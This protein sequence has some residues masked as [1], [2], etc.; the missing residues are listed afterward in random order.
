MPL[1]SFG[2][3]LTFA[4]K[5]EEENKNFYNKSVP[6][7]AAGAQKVFF[8]QLIKEKEKQIKLIQR[9]R[10]ENVSEMILEPI[11]DFKREAYLFDLDSVTC[12]TTEDIINAA[13]KIEKRNFQY[14]LE[15]A[16][17]IKALPE[18]A[19]ALKQLSK[20][21]KNLLKKLDAL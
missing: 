12:T 18:V 13:R 10:R 7:M 20:K 16:E 21:Q 1:I 17:K 11:K 2:A 4:E 15:A 14:Y 19:T 3:I 6:E 8:E 5:I 9:V